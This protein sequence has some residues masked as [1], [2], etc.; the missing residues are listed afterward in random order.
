MGLNMRLKFKF[1]R[2]RM[3][4]IRNKAQHIPFSKVAHDDHLNMACGADK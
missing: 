2:M 4:I 1:E 3:M